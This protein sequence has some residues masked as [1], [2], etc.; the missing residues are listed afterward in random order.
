MGRLKV[1]TLNVAGLN[2]TTNQKMGGLLRWANEIQLDILCIQEHNA[3]RERLAS[4]SAMAW[5]AGFCIR[6]GVATRT[7]GRG[8]TAVLARRS[9]FDLSIDE[10]RLHGEMSGGVTKM[11]VKW[12]DQWMNFVS[13]YVC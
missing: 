12:K 6:L 7:G 4:W 2:D 10:S 11:K 3:P 5:R 1:A 9:T 13:I 8:G